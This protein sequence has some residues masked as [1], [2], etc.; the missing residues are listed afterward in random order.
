MGPPTRVR[1]NGVALGM[2]AISLVVTSTLQQSATRDVLAQ[3]GLMLDSATAIRS[4]TDTEIGPLLDDKMA[5]AFRPQSVPFYA[6][7]QNFL[8]LHKEHPD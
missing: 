6:A 8:T 4:Y 3:A 1:V 2:V 5:V 7:T